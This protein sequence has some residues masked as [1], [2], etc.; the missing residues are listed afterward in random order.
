M[1]LI[2]L[3]CLTYFWL[4]LKTARLPGYEIQSCDT[5]VI[6]VIELG[7]VCNGENSVC[8]GRFGFDFKCHCLYTLTCAGV[9]H[10]DAV[11]FR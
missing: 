11:Q 9:A 8:V 3:V 10:F 5:A 2:F 1:F 4:W 6:W 7:F